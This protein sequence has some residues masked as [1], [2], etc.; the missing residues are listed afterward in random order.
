MA[1]PVTLRLDEE[2]RQRI[3]RIARRRGVSASQIVREAI[4]NCV[5]REEAASPYDALADLVGT[6][7]G[8]D[9]HRSE[10]TGRRFQQILRSRR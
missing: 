7:R 6:V 3:A 9:R 1:S 8:G 4:R 5:E 2:T 10:A